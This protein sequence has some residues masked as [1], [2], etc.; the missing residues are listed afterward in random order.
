MDPELIPILATAC[1]GLFAAA[2]AY[3]G[4]VLAVRPRAPH[5]A[6]TGFEA[7]RR[8][9]IRQGS[10]VYRLAEPWVDRLARFN[11]SR[12]KPEKLAALGRELRAAGTREPWHPEEYMAQNQL[13]AVFGGLFGAVFGWV[14]TETL[15]GLFAFALAFAWL[16]Y[17]LL[18]G[19]PAR[20]ATARRRRL[21]ERLPF[22]VDLMALMLEAGASFPE[23]LTAVVN[24]YKGHPVGEVFGEVQRETALGRTRR[25]AFLD[26]QQRLPDEDLSELIFAI[27]KGEELGTPLGQ[28]F[29]TQADQMRLKFA[30]RQEKE[31]AEAQVAIVFPGMVIMLACLLIIAAP[32]I[33]QA[34]FGA[35][36]GISGMLNG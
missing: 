34:M 22:A 11:R 8:T 17:Q 27:V 32:F 18:M 16:L 5:D 6:P 4:V 33:L 7:V 12:V 15:V 36:G 21:A 29:R 26:L 9:H 24:E 28:I 3:A 20:R 30:Q 1:T 25:E 13:V 19:D 14:L 35:G 23:A 31:S 2:V 10:G